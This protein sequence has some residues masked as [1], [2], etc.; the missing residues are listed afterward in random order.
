MSEPTPFELLAA[1]NEDL[2]A[3]LELANER[4]FYQ[5]A[6]IARLEAELREAFV[7]QAGK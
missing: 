1:E 3:K 5:A 7:G 4:A 2:R 6:R